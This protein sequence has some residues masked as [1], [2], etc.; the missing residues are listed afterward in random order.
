MFEQQ[1][2]ELTLNDFA[3]VVKI[4]DMVSRRGAFGGEE[5]AD[6][7]ILRNKIVMFVNQ[8]QPAQQAAP[9]EVEAEKEEE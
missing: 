4:I 5:L 2:V 7:G 9:T 8:N 6:V 1:R 3:N